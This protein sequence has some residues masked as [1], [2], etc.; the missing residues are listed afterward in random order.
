VLNNVAQGKAGEP[1]RAE[2]PPWETYPKRGT[3]RNLRGYS[4]TR[5]GPHLADARIGYPGLCCETPSVLKR[6]VR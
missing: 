6:I 2:P 5:G 3:S 1:R 4:R